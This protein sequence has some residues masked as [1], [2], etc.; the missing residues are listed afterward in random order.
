MLS[1]GRVRERSPHLRTICLRR[2]SSMGARKWGG[3]FHCPA[4]DG[5]VGIRNA[6]DSELG[7]RVIQGFGRR[8]IQGSGGGRF[9][10]RE[11]GDSGFGRRGS[12]GG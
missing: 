4:R 12:G 6:G 1:V 10:V 8:V 9:R 2:L 11:E 7:R 5:S 3:C